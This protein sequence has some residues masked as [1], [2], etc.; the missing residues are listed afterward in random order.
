LQRR[1]IVSPKNFLG[2]AETSKGSKTWVV[3]FYADVVYADGTIDQVE[4]QFS[5]TANNANV[6]G[7]YVFG[8]EHDLSGYTLVYDIKGN[9]SNIKTL[10]LR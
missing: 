5:F 4:Y 8:T 7:T 10:E 6:S 3:S 9:G 2:I 1:S